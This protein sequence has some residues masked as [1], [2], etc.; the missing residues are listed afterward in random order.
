MPVGVSHHG[1]TVGN[2]HH[3]NHAG[4]GL[5]LAGVKAFHGAA[6]DRALLQAGKHHA[7]QFDINAKF[8][9]A[10]DLA[11]GV[12][13][14][15][16]LA[17]QTKIFRVFQRYF[18]G[19]GQLRC[20]FCERAIGGFFPVGSDDYSLIGCQRGGIHVPLCSGSRNQHGAH[21]CTRCAQLFP[22]FTN[23]R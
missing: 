13:A 14:F 1:H 4:H 19:H 15:G 9:G 16:G 8:G 7:G 22:S 6:N 5:G 17:D 21:L 11:W 3:V 18:F 20:G 10:V 23:R 2:L 12:Q